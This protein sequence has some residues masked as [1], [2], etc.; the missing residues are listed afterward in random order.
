MSLVR[1]LV[2]VCMRHNIHFRARHIPGQHNYLA[3]CLS[4]MQIHKFHAAARRAD[5][6][7]TTLSVNLQPR[8]F[9]LG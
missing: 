1:K 9:I 5:P 3:D 2:V 8:H 6:L 4:R 7:P